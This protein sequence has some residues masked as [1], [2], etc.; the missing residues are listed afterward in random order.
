MADII[1][2]ILAHK[3][4]L[5]IAVLAACVAVLG[6]ALISTRTI[7]AYERYVLRDQ[8]A[9]H[10]HRTSTGLVLGAGITKDGKPY[11]ELRFRLDVAADALQAGYVDKLIVSGDNRFTGYDEPTAMKRYLVD[12]RDIPADKIQPDFAGRSTYESCERAAKVFELDR[13]IL[14]SAGSHLPRAIYLC[15]H[16]GVEAYGIASTA[17]ASNAG[18]REA[19]ARVKALFNVYVRG[20][21]TIL[22]SP[23][24]MR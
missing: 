6:I 24:P 18:R 20:E 13:V 8:S 2:I 16:F 7:S 3:Q 17:E 5:M 12:E 1:R 23:I 11:S 22:G 14:F 19:M 9:M 15:R 21:K 10:A 4:W